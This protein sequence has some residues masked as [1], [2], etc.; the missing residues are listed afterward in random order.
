MSESIIN[1]RIAD[2][3]IILPS[4]ER[5]PVPRTRDA[6]E[7]A[8]AAKKK[9]AE[10]F[11]ER[12]AADAAARGAAN[13][14]RARL[15][16][17]YADD[18]DVDVDDDEL[19][20]VVFEARRQA[21]KAQLKLT[22]RLDRERAAYGALVEAITAERDAWATIARA[23]AKKALTRLATA[24]RMAEGARDD[25]EATLGV[26]RTVET[27]GKLTPSLVPDSYTIPIVS[28]VTGLRD[29]LA[30]ATH[31]LEARS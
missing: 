20:E 26:L 15:S 11:R 27:P 13:V 6:L 29:A 16:E 7:R 23:D 9:T 2:R 31:E 4:P 14:E 19:G 1:A 22:A 25:L 10:A 12:D 21:E 5:I 30:K 28:G 3:H 17:R 8:L 18:D 24:V